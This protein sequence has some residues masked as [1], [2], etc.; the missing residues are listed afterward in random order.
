INQTGHEA[1]SPGSYKSVKFNPEKIHHGN[2]DSN[3]DP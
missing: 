1:L 2:L 3:P